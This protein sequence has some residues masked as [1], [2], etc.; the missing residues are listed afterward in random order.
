M[1]QTF[2]QAQ[3]PTRQSLLTNAASTQGHIHD[4]PESRDCHTGEIAKRVDQTQQKLPWY[5]VAV[6][7]RYWRTPMLLAIS[8]EALETCTRKVAT[9]FMRLPSHCVGTDRIGVSAMHQRGT[10]S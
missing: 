4:V 6:P 2:A 8:V 1:S 9:T 10:D 3:P 7:S 5:D